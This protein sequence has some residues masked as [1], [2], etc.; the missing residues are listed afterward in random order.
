MKNSESWMK[1]KYISLIC[2]AVIILFIIFVSIVASVSDENR[3]EYKLSEDEFG[4]YYIVTDIKNTYRGG[5]FCKDSLTIPSTHKGLPVK[6]I[7]KVS[8][9]SIKEI[10]ISDNITHI[11]SDAFSNNNSIQ[12]VVLPDSVISIGSYAFNNCSSITNIT[13]PDSVTSIGYNAFSGCKKL[14][15]IIFTNTATWYRTTNISNWENKI[16]GTQT[17]VTDST[18]N[19]TDFKDIYKDFYWYKL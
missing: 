9:T 1:I 18:T 12:T 11:L 6:K 4:S 13:I 5:W 16:D 17:D 15:N 7:E 10:I 19:A 2:V 3:L 8:T 14:S